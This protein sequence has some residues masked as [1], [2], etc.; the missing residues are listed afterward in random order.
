MK[1]NLLGASLVDAVRPLLAAAVR[2]ALGPDGRTGLHRQDGRLDGVVGTRLAQPDAG[3]VGVSVHP[4]QVQVSNQGAA[5]SRIV[6]F[7]SR[8]GVF[9]AAAENQVHLLQAFQGDAEA[10]ILFSDGL[11]NPAFN[12]TLSPGRLVRAITVNNSRA[13]EI[14]AVTIGDYFKYRGTVEFMESLAR[15]NGGG[16]L[17]LA[18]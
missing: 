12:N 8:Q 16:F 9:G 1:T 17:A 14:H 10:L 2:L 7:D 3:Q 6:E 13:Q 15:A 18:D 4:G 11:P 5:G